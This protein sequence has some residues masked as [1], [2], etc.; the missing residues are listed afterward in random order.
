MKKHMKPCDTWGP[1]LAEHRTGRYAPSEG[2]CNEGFDNQFEDH[3]D[4][5]KRKE[6]EATVT[7]F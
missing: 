1:M 7:L 2:V 6:F 4:K 5:L 3:V